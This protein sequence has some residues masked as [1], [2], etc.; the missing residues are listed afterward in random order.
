MSFLVVGRNSFLAGR[1][2]A[3]SQI[4][5]DC[6]FITHQEAETAPPSELQPFDCIIN[7]AI[8]PG[9]RSERY[10]MERD[11][12]L[13]LAQKTPSQGR[14]IMLSSRAVYGRDVAMGAKETEPATGNETTYGRNKLET[15]H[16][17]TE[18]LGDRLTVLRIANIIGDE[19]GSGRRTFMSLALE[20]LKSENEILLD[21]SPDVRRDFLPDNV[22]VRVLDAALQD[23][24]GGPLNVG[25]GLP[26]RVSDIAGWLIEGFGAG[27][28]V[29]SDRRVHDEFV[30]NTERLKAR[31]GIGC[32]VEDIAKHC[33]NIGRTLRER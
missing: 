23:P 24:Q 2:R 30:L 28:I 20:R 31:Y 26:V 12:D 25:S 21:I 4:A 14:Y 7:F 11:F 6:H 10:A 5:A 22:F 17:L 1:F 32:A 27:Q 29:V 13:K 19:L 16:R 18:L 3:L 9:Y 33:R 15:E 8:D